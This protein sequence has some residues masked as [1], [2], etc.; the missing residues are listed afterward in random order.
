LKSHLLFLLVL[1]SL[2]TVDG[3][4]KPGLQEHWMGLSMDDGIGF[5]A[6]TGFQQ[7]LFGKA[8]LDLSI[9]ASYNVLRPQPDVK[10]LMTSVRLGFGILL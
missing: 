10:R 6:A 5:G 4:G 7:R 8:Y 2:L 3:E 9:S 1:I